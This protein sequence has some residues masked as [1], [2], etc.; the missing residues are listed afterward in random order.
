MACLPDML[1]PMLTAYVTALQSTLGDD[2]VGVYLTGSAAAGEFEPAGSDVD[3]LVLLQSAASTEHL[4]P[5]GDVHRGL[6]ALPYG[7]RLEIEYAGVSQLRPDGIQGP[8]V[9][10]S[11]GADL[12]LGP[13]NAAADD[14]HGARTLGIALFGPSPESV[15]PDVD[16]LTLIVSLESW[17]LDLSQRD[18]K[19][20]D[21]GPHDYAE[22]TLNIARCLFGV[23]HGR[24]SSKQQAAV[25][26]SERAPELHTTLAKALDIRR[27]TR[28]TTIGPR[29]FRNFAVQ[30]LAVKGHS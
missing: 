23:E 13:S 17:L 5:L 7:D 6:A 24:G 14:I 20:A 11:P 12:R 28:E 1:R 30:A 27:G 10:I 3:L 4:E 25:W 18:R 19:Q 9:S 2:L 15:F 26:L 16:R 29:E 21:A 8:S 22:W